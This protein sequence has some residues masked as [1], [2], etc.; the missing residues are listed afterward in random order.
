MV[1]FNEHTYFVG[2]KL[3][4]CPDYQSDNA[5]TVGWSPLGEI[6]AIDVAVGPARRYYV[7]CRHAPFSIRDG[8][9]NGETL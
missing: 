3:L 1:A 7:T 9:Y 4:A 5:R 8:F 6:A 2:V